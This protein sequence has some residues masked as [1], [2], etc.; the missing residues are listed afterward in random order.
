MNIWLNGIDAPKAPT[1]SEY[2]AV[3]VSSHVTTDAPPAAPAAATDRFSVSG[4][5]AGRTHAVASAENERPP[6]ES[7]VAAGLPPAPQ[8]SSRWTVEYVRQPSPF[9]AASRTRSVTSPRWW[10]PAPVRSSGR[11]CGPEPAQWTRASGACSGSVYENSGSETGETASTVPVLR[12]TP[13]SRPSAA[14]PPTAAS[15]SLANC[16]VAAAS[17]D[18]DARGGSQ[19][20]VA[21]A[22][23]AGAAVATAA[24]AA[25]AGVVGSL[26]GA[27]H[28]MASA[29]ATGRSGAALTTWP[30]ML[31]RRSTLHGSVHATRLCASLSS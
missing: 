9:L 16:A 15:P 21:G 13:S 11:G 19:A 14:P 17:A 18:S 4:A 24:V 26:A 25:L 20:A 12:R 2:D 1:S 7:T 27:A 31:V 22:A 29:A 30:P 28:A 10:K 6:S 23:V 8:S 5:P 3:F